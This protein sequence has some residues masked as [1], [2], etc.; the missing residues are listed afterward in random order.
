MEAGLYTKRLPDFLS[1]QT[2]GG[3]VPASTEIGVERMKEFHCS[4]CQADLSR[5]VAYGVKTTLCLMADQ[6]AAQIRRAAADLAAELYE[7]CS[8]EIRKELITT[9]GNCAEGFASLITNVAE[10]FGNEV[11]G[12]DQ[13]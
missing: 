8:P 13:P 2:D 9:L 7:T 10:D 5:A 1:L 6:F 3:I 12:K 11:L 4:Q